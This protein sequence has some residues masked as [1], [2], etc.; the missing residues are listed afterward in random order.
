MSRDIEK[1]CKT[2]VRKTQTKVKP[3]P[4][5]NKKG[6][7]AFCCPK[8]PTFDFLKFKFLSN[9]SKRILK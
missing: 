9:R 7:C 3:K 4:K 6:F 8:K 1:D 2:A 5:K